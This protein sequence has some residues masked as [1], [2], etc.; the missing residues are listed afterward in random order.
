M[1]LCVYMQCWAIWE[2]RVSPPSDPLVRREPP[3]PLA[4]KEENGFGECV[5]VVVIGEARVAME[6]E[7]IAEERE[8]EEEEEEEEKA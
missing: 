3:R 6:R 7:G 4:F 8:A 1:Y 5:S 2:T